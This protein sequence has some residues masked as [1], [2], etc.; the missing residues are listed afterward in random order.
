[1]LNYNINY[2]NFIKYMGSKSN[3]LDF[4]MNGINDAYIRG[5]T[6]VDLFSGSATI[7]GALRGHAP[8][9]SNDI[10][11][12][13][14]ILSEAYLSNYDWYS[15]L[16]IIDEIIASAELKYEELI[17][18]FDIDILEFNYNRDLTLDEFH[19]LEERQKELKARENWNDDY[20]L[21]SRFY[22]GT[23]WSYVQCV[24]ID[25]FRCTAD[26]YADSNMKSAILSAL[27]FAMSYNA[28]STGHYAQYR[29]ARDDKSMNDIL[30]YRRKDIVPY[31][32]RKLEELRDEMIHENGYSYQTYA[33]DY[34]ECL[35]K[36]PESSTVYADPPY[37]FVHYSRF[38]HAIETLVRYDY[39]DIKHKGRYRE[40]RHQSP[41]SIKSKVSDAFRALFDL[42][43]VK[44]SNLVLS[45]SNTGMIELDAI[46]EIANEIMKDYEISI[47]T[48]AYK[49]ST[50]GRKEDKSR[51]VQEALIIAKKRGR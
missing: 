38:Y 25:A 31:V 47:A 39:P 18:T 49:H 45:Y 29:D 34:K 44:N 23:Y 21:F 22:S 2:P 43:R 50:M 30:I 36:I 24:W 51:D 5:G 26:A 28:Q 8:V 40:D 13:S 12:Y 37:C 6:V 15:N 3:I 19:L 20:H 9:I 41:F 14:K 42:V 11:A 1:M 32:R 4:V 27:M 16:T 17:Q 46:L 7:S 48:M 33:L 10:Q 35:R